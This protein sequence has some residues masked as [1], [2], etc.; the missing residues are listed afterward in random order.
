[1]KRK[2]L[3]LAPEVL[4][5][6]AANFSIHGQ[7]HAENAARLADYLHQYGLTYS[8]LAARFQLSQAP[9]PA[10]PTATTE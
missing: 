6:V 8:D 3:Q 4:A 10:K 7:T 5:R 2:L 9:S 1:M